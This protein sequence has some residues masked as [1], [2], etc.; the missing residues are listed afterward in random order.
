MIPGISYVV[1]AKDELV[2]LQRLLP[3]LLKHYVPAEDEIIIQ[4]DTT[5]SDEVYD[6]VKMI[7]STG[8][9]F[10]VIEYPLNG[11]FASFKNN[12][13]KYCTKDFVFNIDADELP[14]ESLLMTLKEILYNNPEIDMYLVPRI[15]VV[16]GVTPEYVKNQGWVINEKGYINFPD[17][18]MRI[19]KNN[20][21][22]RWINK[23]H[24][25]LTGYSTHAAL[26]TE[27]EDYCLLHVK[28]FERQKRANEYYAQLLK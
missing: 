15:N 4:L 1:T 7:E 12:Y 2:E 9:N 19:F 11:D 26:P 16:A 3:R 5:R 14:H 24:E 13:I 22:I 20:G 10:K 17:A 28:S 8:V 6:Y 18:Q 27:T 25:V 23:V 21:E